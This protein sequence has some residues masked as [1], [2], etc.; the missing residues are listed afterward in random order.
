MEQSERSPVVLVH[1]LT[2]N[3]SSVSKFF[4]GV[5]AN[6][7][8]AGYD[9]ATPRLDSRAT[10]SER[11]VALKRFIR[12]TFGRT[13]VHLV[14]HSLGGLDARYLVSRLGFEKQVR[15]LTTIGTPHHGTPFADWLL[16]L[17]PT[18]LR[19]WLAWIGIPVN[20]IH[21]LSTA[22]AEHFKQQIQ[23]V[24]G[25]RTLSVAGACPANWLNLGWRFPS[26]LV[27]QQEGANDGVVSAASARWGQRHETWT[28]DHLNLVNK[29][30]RL[31]LK[32]GAWQDRSR[33]YLRLIVEHESCG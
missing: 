10:M 15:S 17:S 7:R 30:N 26:W 14:A 25:L 22:Y 28:A 21:T 4:P 33:D 16:R 5:V 2:G 6:L 19:P 11:A 29:P 3:R 12:G 24:P 18:R 9:V 1:G 20:T 32:V 31:M 27:A 23:D 8:A 13:P